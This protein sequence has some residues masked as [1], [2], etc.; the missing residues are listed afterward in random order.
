MV[1]G[2]LNWLRQCSPQR[3]W[4]SG[5]FNFLRNAH[6]CEM[7]RYQLCTLGLIYDQTSSM[8]R[9]FS[10][11]DA[12]ILQVMFSLATD[13]LGSLGMRWCELSK[14]QIMRLDDLMQH[15]H[16]FFGVQNFIHLGWSRWL[17][18]REIDLISL[19]VFMVFLWYWD[20]CKIRCLDCL[21][22]LLV[23]HHCTC[24]KD[25]IV[26]YLSSF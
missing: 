15:L 12:A 8:T 18:W 22:L 23:V 16:G 7:N 11:K 13:V 17:T 26:S 19:W 4:G 5:I 1:R 10:M 3:F 2:H 25:N 6:I 9:H 14:G 20:F 21:W 24:H